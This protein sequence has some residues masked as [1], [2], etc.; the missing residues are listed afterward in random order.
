MQSEGLKIQDEVLKEGQIQPLLK[1]HEQSQL[2]FIKN[3]IDYA[4]RQRDQKLREFN[5]LDFMTEDQANRDIRNSFIRPKKNDDEVRINTGTVE[6][7]MLTIVNEVL[8]LNMQPEIHVFDENDKPVQELGEV[9]ENIVKRTN[10]QE[11]DEDLK[12]PMLWDLATRRIM[13]CEEYQEEKECVDKKKKKYDLEKGEIEFDTK[14]YKISRPRKRLLDARTVLFG[15][16]SIPA[17]RYNEQ[18][19]IVKYDR[20]HWRT[21]YSVF[22]KFANWK[23]VK[24]GGSSNDMSWFQ[25]VFDW[26]LYSELSEEEVEILYYYSYPD[27]EYQIIIN[28][29]PMLPP[30]TPLPWEYE[31]YSIQGFV[32]REMEQHL[33]YGQLYSINARVLAGLQDEMIRLIVRKWRKSIEPSVIVKGKK[34][35]SRDIWGTGAII[36]GID[37]EDVKTLG[38]D[39][40]VTSSEMETLNLVSAKIEEEIGVSKLFQGMSD[41]RMTATQALE[42]MK[43]AVKSIGLLVYAWARVVRTMTYLRIYNVIEN[44]TY[45]QDI[46]YENGE[47]EKVYKSFTIEDTK[48]DNDVSGSMVVNFT[49][50]DVPLEILESVD[51]YERHEKKKGNHVRFKFINVDKL[52]QFRFHWFVSVQPQEK[53]STALQKIMYSDQL[54]QAVG[55]MNMTGRRINADT[56]VNDFER[57][58]KKKNAFEQAPPPQQMMGGL[59]GE[60]PQSGVPAEIAQAS[61]GL[62]QSPVG[63]QVASAVSKSTKRPSVNSLTAGGNV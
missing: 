9:F 4:K 38:D 13:F 59:M 39:K 34:V 46:N 14:T 15:D 19:Y 44:N 33:A 27:D 45:P 16:M 43:Q 61:E 51:E 7:K 1:E 56:W 22:G 54:N 26:R 31:G 2:D 8:N 29:V 30:N 60:V 11:D 24:P 57:I 40:G 18:P 3:R 12:F 48:L 62:G 21:A 58:W 5:G 63:S 10:E 23:Y 25:G 52:R 42:Q 28:G 49:D 53:D 41:K 47:I 6:K 37:P 35:L 50:K 17:H 55:L 32:S 36:S 20:K